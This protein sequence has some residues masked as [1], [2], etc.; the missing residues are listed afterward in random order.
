MDTKSRTFG[1]LLLG[2]ALVTTMAM[3]GVVAADGDANESSEDNDTETAYSVHA[4]NMSE[5]GD[6]VTPNVVMPYVAH[7]DDDGATTPTTCECTSW[8]GD[9][10]ITCGDDPGEEGS[11][12]ACCWRE[13][14]DWSVDECHCAC[15]S[16]M[17]EC[18]AWAQEESG[19]NGYTM[20]E[21][22]TAS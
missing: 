1:H 14:K 22:E 11:T 6:A 4:A 5:A 2:F 18:D 21:T 19:D 10:D 12:Y 15:K 8:G 3:A 16:S 13:Q 17:T 20:Y 9:C 7:D